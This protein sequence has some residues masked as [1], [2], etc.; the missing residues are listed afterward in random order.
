MRLM[1]VK[2]CGPILKKKKKSD[3]LPGYIGSMTPQILFIHYLWIALF[4]NRVEEFPA[5]FSTVWI[6]EISFF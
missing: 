6:S 2:N 5:A 1:Q 3:I 4:G